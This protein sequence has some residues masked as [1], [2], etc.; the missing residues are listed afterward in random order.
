MNYDS[1]RLRRQIDFVIEIDKLKNIYRQTHVLGEDR[2]ENDA[3]HSWHIALMAFLLA[4]HSNQKVDVLKV[5]KMLLV[6][7]IVEI[8]AGDT[9]CYDSE[10][11]KTKAD[12]EEKAARRIFGILPQDQSEE[13]YGLWREFEDGITPEAGFADVLDR[14]QPLILNYTK[15]GISWKEHDVCRSQV[16]NRYAKT[17]SSSKDLTQLALSLIDDASKKGWLKK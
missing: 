10:G 4:E 1:E 5:M 14:I 7:D 12:R 15:D 3:E 11:Y 2:K 9:F 8:D 13:F 16:E 17:S 6:H